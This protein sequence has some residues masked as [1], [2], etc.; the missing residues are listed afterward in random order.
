MRPAPA[1][2]RRVIRRDQLG[3]Q[4]LRGREVLPQLAALHQQP[5]RRVLQLAQPRHA[6]GLGKII[7]H[8]GEKY[9]VAASLLALVRV[10]SST[11]TVLARNLLRH[12]SFST[13]SSSFR[14]QSEAILKQVE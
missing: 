3:E 14:S 8:Y 11:M 6:A 10:S 2:A 13:P 4:L 7:S 9:L 5:P 1:P 12:T